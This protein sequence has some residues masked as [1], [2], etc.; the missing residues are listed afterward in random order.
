L[1]VWTRNTQHKFY[2]TYSCEV[3]LTRTFAFARMTEPN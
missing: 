3:Q 1:K 2:Y